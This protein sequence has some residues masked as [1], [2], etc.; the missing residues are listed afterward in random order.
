MWFVFAIV[1]AL[2]WGGSDLFSKMGT[3]PKDKYSHWRMVIMVGLVMGIHAV[4]YILFTGIRYDPVNIIRYFPVSFLYI[5]SMVIGYAGL[6][7]IELSISSP[8]CNSSGAVA[9]L[10]CFVFL[11]EEIEPLQIPAMVMIFAGILLLSIFQK[12]KDDTERLQNNEKV[13]KKYRIGFIAILLPI[14]YCVIDA[15]GTFADALVLDEDSVLASNGVPFINEDQANLSYEFTFLI[16][17][18]LAFI[19]IVFVRRQ[20][21]SLWGERVK[22]L[23][24][25]CETAGQFCYIYAIASPE[26]V[27]AIPIISSYCIFSVIFSRIVLKEKLSAKQYAA[28]ILVIA[29]VVLLGVVDGILEAG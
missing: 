25:I 1:C 9:V 20:K 22:G 16:C 12:K 21:F 7:Y 26:K 4:L 3:D 15:L 11:N 8:I 24:A 23:G 6:R 10:L 14:L 29:G 13:D 17:A 5:L 19:Y 27:I 28:I 2:M 18:V